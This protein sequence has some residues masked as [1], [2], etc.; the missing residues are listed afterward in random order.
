[1]DFDVNEMMR[2]AIN[3]A[4]KARAHKNHP[5]GALLVD[6]SG[7]ILL[8]AENSVESD[9]DLTSHAEMNLISMATKKYNKEFLKKCILISSAEPCPMCSGA[10]FWSNIGTVIYGLSAQWLY[11]ISDPQHKNSLSL[12]CRDVLQSGSKVINVIGPIL[13]EE[14][15][16]PH[17]E[18]WKFD[19]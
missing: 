9:M 13:E 10:I 16:E 12:S 8:K 15:R 18:F 5:F 11:E 3:L 19:E 7:K 6:E 2:I 1:M 14:A 4:W 17:L